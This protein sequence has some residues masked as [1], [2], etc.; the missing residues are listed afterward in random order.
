MRPECEEGRH[1]HLGVTNSDM[2]AAKRQGGAT[3]AL[4]AEIIALDE[5]LIDYDHALAKLREEQRDIQASIEAT[6]HGRADRARRRGAK[7]AA[8][9]TLLGR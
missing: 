9:Q 8:L 4:L 2:W 6:D 1:D 5:E 7:M 3:T